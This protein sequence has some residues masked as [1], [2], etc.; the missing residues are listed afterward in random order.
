MTPVIEGD[1]SYDCSK[2]YSFS[3]FRTRRRNWN[4]VLEDRERIAKPTELVVVVLVRHYFVI[5][6][7]TIVF[8]NTYLIVR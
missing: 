7:F 3:K 8:N 2:S 6:K 1:Y 5:G 4:G